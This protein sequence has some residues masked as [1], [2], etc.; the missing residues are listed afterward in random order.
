[1]FK[2][3][4]LKKR[5]ISD[6]E[7]YEILKE[8]KYGVLSTV[9]TDGY[10]YGIPISYVSLDNN[11]YF[12]CAL[13]GSKLE[14]IKNNNKVSFCVVG[15]TEIIPEKFTT[16]YE[17]VVVFGKAVEVHDEEKERALLALLEKY[18]KD[19]MDKGRIY[20]N[21]AKSKTKVIK[22]II[23]NISGKSNK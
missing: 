21:N 13:E 11:I 10:A 20:V 17:S 4:R 8:G 15:E 16:K 14:N 2:D 6:S 12:H 22:I 18:S 9:N 23:E 7:S 1:M 19:Y 5:K 3:M